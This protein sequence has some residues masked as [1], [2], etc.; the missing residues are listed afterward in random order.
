M[1]AD[2]VRTLPPMTGRL[3]D[4]VSAKTPPGREG[5]LFAIAA[6]S[7]VGIGLFSILADSI[8]D[9]PRL[10]V[11]LGNM[12]APWGFVA[13]LVGRRAT[14]NRRGAIAGATTLVVGVV[15]YYI[16]AAI[17]WYDFGGQTIAW[18]VVALVAGPVMGLCGAATA[19]RPS[20]PPIAAVVAPSAMLVAEALYQLDSYKA[21]RWN[22]ATV[23]YRLAELGLALALVAGGF[24]LP[25]MLVKDPHDRHLAYLLVPVVAVVGAAGLVMFERL[26]VRIA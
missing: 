17:R 22:L 1:S 14:S 15:V 13:F 12:A 6:A 9:T 4:D 5:R 3:E 8:T 26:I 11:L 18:T 25:R 10:F 20:R 7:G 23:Q 19:A 2:P 16:G 21:W 24:L